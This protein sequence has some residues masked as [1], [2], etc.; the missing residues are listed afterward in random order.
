MPT[1]LPYSLTLPEIPG[2]M[3]L[4]GKPGTLTT[5][6]AKKL[7]E[8]LRSSYVATSGRVEELIEVSPLAANRPSAVGAGLLNYSQDDDRLLLDDGSGSWV[9][10]KH[11]SSEISDWD[12][13][14]L[15]LTAGSGKSLTGNLHIDKANAALYLQHNGA[16]DYTLQSDSALVYAVR[17]VVD[18]GQP[19]I[20]LDPYPNDGVSNALVQMFRT[21]NTTGTPSLAIY[22][23]NNTSTEQH[24]LEATAT[25]DAVFCQQGGN[26]TIEEGYLYLDKTSTPTIYLREN[27]SDTNYSGI[28]D[29]TGIMSVR[30]Y[31]S[32]GQAVVRIDPY[33]GDGTSNA[34]VQMF[35]TTNTTGTPFLAIY[36]GDNSVTEQHR[37]EAGA[38][39]DAEFCK[40][41]GNIKQGGTN[42]S[43]VGHTHDDRY[44]TEAETTAFLAGKSNTGHTHLEADITDLGTYLPLT[45][46]S[47]KRITGDLYFEN[48]QTI[49]FRNSGNTADIAA[50][51]VTA[52]NFVF[53]G[54]SASNY[55][56]YIKGDDI[57]L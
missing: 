42:V 2:A 24:R 51:Q 29:N 21:T 7:H 33:P 3:A 18:S 40:G 17:K 39:G 35:R 28:Y 56:T 52:D 41:G 5:E 16:T 4:G 36:R 44:Y 9:S 46:G 50:V 8:A 45:A 38:T 27:G 15:P 34:L 25:G 47:G 57:F 6:Y 10:H 53:L 19:V 22:L 55:D 43:L 14:Y 32:A 12:G 54:H 1:R 48:N 31:I 13:P 37:L 20:R 11:P 49:N 30:K 23:G 26:V